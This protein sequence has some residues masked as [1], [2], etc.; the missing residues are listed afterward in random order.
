MARTIYF[1]DGSREVLCAGDNERI[2]LERILRKRLGE[3]VVELFQEIADPNVGL[4]DELK[5]YEVSCDD[6]RK[7]LQDTIDEL[8][9]ILG[10]LDTN[11]SYR[12][13]TMAAIQRLVKTI[14]NQL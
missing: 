14:N 7:L 2:V 13:E 8:C 4:E 9:R 1:L 3:D 12:K 5:S 10:V 11:R 6:Y